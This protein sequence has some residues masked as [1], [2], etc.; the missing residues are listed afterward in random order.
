MYMNLRFELGTHLPTLT[1]SNATTEEINMK[2][3]LPWRL[4]AGFLS[5]IMMILVMVLVSSH[6]SA[7]V[8]LP[9]VISDNMVLQRHIS[10]PIWGTADP[11]EKVTVTFGK[12]KVSAT[13]DN[14]GKWSIKLR[15][16]N[17]GG[18]NE[19][20]VAGKNKIVLKNVMIG[21]VWV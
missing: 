18:P 2:R 14:D 13:A 6:V 1:E 3:K 4:R 12:Q 11:N 7:D 19:L 15:S 16:L 5:C 17:A 9:A 10:V 8:K 21:D 20:T